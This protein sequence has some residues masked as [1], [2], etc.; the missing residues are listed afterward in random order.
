[1]ARIRKKT[2]YHENIKDKKYFIH[3]LNELDLISKFM[4]YFYIIEIMDLL[5]NEELKVESF[6][7]QVFPVVASTFNKAVHTV[8]RDIRHYIK[9]CWNEKLQ[10]L[11]EKTEHQKEYPTCSEFILMLKNYIISGLI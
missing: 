8:E 3:K 5:I 1:M 6:S 9:L 7:R 10:K 4:G 2:K 11:F